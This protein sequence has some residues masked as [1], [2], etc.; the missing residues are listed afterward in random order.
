[1]VDLLNGLYQIKLI[2]C[3]YALI[4]RDLNTL[5]WSVQIIAPYVEGKHLNNP[6]KTFKKIKNIKNI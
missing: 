5:E 4:L 6:L 1:M 3:Q 2:W